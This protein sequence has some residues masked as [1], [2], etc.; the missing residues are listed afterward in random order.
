MICY[1]NGPAML[2]WGS[3]EAYCLSSNSVSGSERVNLSAPNLETVTSV[4]ANQKQQQKLDNNINDWKRYDPQFLMLWTHY[5]FLRCNEEKI[6]KQGVFLSYQ[7]AC[8]VYI[9][10]PCKTLLHYQV[11]LKSLANLQNNC[12]RA[13]CKL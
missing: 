2:D 6:N 1:R 4:V 7:K 10:R 5:A 8:F 9:C 3:V 12:F 11:G 13:I